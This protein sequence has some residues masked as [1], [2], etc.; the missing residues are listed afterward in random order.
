MVLPTVSPAG[1]WDVA[2]EI[3]DPP[4]YEANGG[5]NRTWPAPKAIGEDAA[6]QRERIA[7]RGLGPWDGAPKDTHV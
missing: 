2:L 4:G 6:G 1:N 3:I 5:V 7:G